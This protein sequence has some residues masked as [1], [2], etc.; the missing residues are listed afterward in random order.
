MCV[1]S[2]Y[3]GKRQAAPVV[4]E[5]LRK[6]EGFWAGF[7]TGIAS[8]D[9][10]E[11]CLRKCCGSTDAFAE[12]F[13]T[14]SFPGTMAI[15]HSRTASGGLEVRAQPHLAVGRSV[16][17][18]SQGAAGVFADK[19]SQYTDV[20]MELYADG[21]HLL[22]GALPNDGTRLNPAMTTPDGKQ[23]CPADIELNCIE[24]NYRSNGGD[25]ISALRDAALPL[26]GEHCSICLFADKP[27]VIGFINMNQ[28]VCY[29]FEEDGVYMATSMAALPGSG[30][31][32][33]GNTIGFITSSGVLHMER[34]GDL[35]LKTAIP[36]G[37]LKAVTDYLRENPRSLMAHIC[38]NA[39]RPL[40][41]KGELDYHSAALYRL[42]EM[43]LKEGLVICETVERPYSVTNLP[44]RCFV[45]SLK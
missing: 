16:T 33:P 30:M 36:D 32:I 21:C 17:L 45:W 9:Q 34:L 29:S 35:P 5:M 23:V 25:I 14:F 26:P 31:E 43:M 44:G 8:C 39:V 13:D 42:M 28:R 40:F 6:I 22:S 11:I 7:Y 20:L 27:G 3:A 41:P 38:D 1:W 15:A 4:F 19:R 37:L 2:A 24:R 12:K 18:L 10:G